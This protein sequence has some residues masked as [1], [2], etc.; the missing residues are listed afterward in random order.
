MRI[1]VFTELYSPS[2]G[3]QETFFAGLGRTLVRRGHTVDVFCIGHEKDLPETEYIDGVTIY[4]GPSRPRYKEPF[5]SFMKR[6]WLSIARY[7]WVVRNV[8]R[9]GQYDCFLLNQWPL[10]HLLLLPQ[11]ARQRALIH[12]CEIRKSRVFRIAQKWLP[13]GAAMN[14]AISDSV[15]E[16]IT[17]AS[18]RPV[19][20]LPSGLDGLPADA[21]GRS[22]RHDILAVGRIMPHK[23]LEFLVEA[24]EILRARGYGGRLK[25]A[26]TGPALNDLRARVAAS[27]VRH[28]IDLLGFISDGDK[29]DLL[30][31]CEL[32]AMPSKR[33]GFPHATSEAISHGLPV[34][35][36]DYSENGTTDIVTRF[37]CGVVT[38]ATPTAFA[39]GITEALGN[40]EMFSA[41]GR[42]AARTLDWSTIA[43]R[44]ET[45]LRR[46]E[47]RST[48]QMEQ[49]T[50]CLPGL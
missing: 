47:P 46:F 28:S 38:D 32:L 33:E 42:K 40:W 25:I 6:D 14:A 39:D 1:A 9:A 21:P 19:L 44:L 36:A 49:K 23:N 13:R 22:A 11:Q 45:E 41:N 37:R 43:Q 8:A 30:T 24:Y 10:L 3:G 7:A 5:I 15:G 50:R 29:V 35:T 20:T 4:R 16:Q 48:D 27:P 17:E 31:T 26:G 34:V 18:G 12:W 2:I